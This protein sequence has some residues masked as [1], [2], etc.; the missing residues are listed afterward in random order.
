MHALIIEDQ[1]M[2]AAMIEDELR[3]LGFETFDHALN[4]EEA[5]R[6]AEERRGST[7][8]SAHAP[9]TNR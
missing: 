5:V 4:E 3:E 2:I 7:S 6:L 8:N 1:F 9:Q